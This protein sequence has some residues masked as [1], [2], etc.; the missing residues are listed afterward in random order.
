[1][2]NMKASFVKPRSRTSGAAQARAPYATYVLS[3]VMSPLAVALLLV[4]LTGPPDAAY[5]RAR[6]PADNVHTTV[7]SQVPLRGTGFRPARGDS[8]LPTLPAG[9]TINVNST[10]QS[11]GNSDDCTLGEAI[12]AANTD[13]R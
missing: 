1:M 12:Q 9:A 10:L 2:T 8:N 13:Q 4:D 7:T 3:A 11:P 5:G 6:A